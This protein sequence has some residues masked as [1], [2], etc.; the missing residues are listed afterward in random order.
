MDCEE[1]PCGSNLMEWLSDLNKNEESKTVTDHSEMNEIPIQR[2]IFEETPERSLDPEITVSWEQKWEERN[3][4]SNKNSQPPKDWSKAMSDK[5]KDLLFNEKAKGHIV[6]PPLAS[7]R[8]ARL[9]KIIKWPNSRNQNQTSLPN[10]RSGSVK[11]K[12]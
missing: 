7:D 3:N 11:K 2:L 9:K 1:S 5:M 12:S 8:P 10:T 6:R 4:S